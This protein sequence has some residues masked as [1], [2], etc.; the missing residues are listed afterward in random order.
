MG[1]AL[2]LGLGQRA[3]DCPVRRGSIGPQ[4]D[5]GRQFFGR[6]ALAQ[7]LEP[8]SAGLGFGCPERR[9]PPRRPALRP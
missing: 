2:V 9:S 5:H 1:E 8:R 7:G 3:P 4:D 6:G